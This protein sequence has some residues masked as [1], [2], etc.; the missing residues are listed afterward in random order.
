MSVTINS[1]KGVQVNLYFFFSLVFGV[2]YSFLKFPFFLQGGMWAESAT[3]YFANSRAGSF[4]TNFLSTEAGYLNIPLRIFA[5]IFS[6]VGVSLSVIPYLYS[7]TGIFISTFIFSFY[8]F[9]VFRKLVPSDLLRFCASLLFCV[10][11]DFE[12]RTFINFLYFSILFLC[13]LLLTL[14]VEP[15]F[16]RNI[17]CL[18]LLLLSKPLILATIPF[19]L[20]TSLKVKNLMFR[21]MS[22]ICMLVATLQILTILENLE[23]FA[24]NSEISLISRFKNSIVFFF[25]FQGAWINLLWKTSIGSTVVIGIFATLVIGY[26]AI[27]AQG[28]IRLAILG[29]LTTI[30]T[31]LLIESF[32]VTNTFGAGNYAIFT[33]GLSLSRYTV[34]IYQLQIVLASIVLSKFYG[35]LL[36]I[37]IR[38]MQYL[39]HLKK[40]AITSFA[41][42]LLALNSLIPSSGFPLTENSRWKHFASKL[43]SGDQ[44]CVPIDPLGWYYSQGCSL[45]FPTGSFQK[46]SGFEIPGLMEGRNFEFK[47]P[48]E[49]RGRDLLMVAIYLK[50]TSGISSLISGEI[51]ISGNGERESKF[52]VNRFVSGRGGMFELV[53][54]PKMNLSIEST[55]RL[56]L[57]ED[58]V[59][60][61][62][63]YSTSGMANI[64]FYGS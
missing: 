40:L 20:L 48:V 35:K 45:I 61:Q 49:L 9:R 1:F 55:L 17:W 33:S 14:L 42:T 29:L 58:V 18:P 53:L 52:Q 28:P 31:I 22:L 63:Q 47:L 10:L 25:G 5:Y 3:N 4:Q 57:S 46:F 30:Y 6:N 39:R 37:N 23:A 44:V 7:M 21:I 13:L 32:A 56:S 2:A 8:N 60:G 54:L 11:S 24:L 43:E 12:T 27:R 59:I 16:L 41:L 15:R 36:D 19:L 50:P 26:F 51:T 62:A 34:P 38:G 64:L